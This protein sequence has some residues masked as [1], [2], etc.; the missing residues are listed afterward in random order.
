[1]RRLAV[2]YSDVEY[3]AGVRSNIETRDELALLDA[4]TTEVLDILEN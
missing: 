4:K 3:G 2:R 1:M